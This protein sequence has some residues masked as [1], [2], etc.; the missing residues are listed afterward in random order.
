MYR[1][2][3]R[4]V[5]EKMQ[6]EIVSECVKCEVIAQNHQEHPN[7]NKLSNVQVMA[8]MRIQMHSSIDRNA[9]VCSSEV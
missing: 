2:C 3:D 7:M 6:S 1:R 5:N 9:L 8:I 4:N